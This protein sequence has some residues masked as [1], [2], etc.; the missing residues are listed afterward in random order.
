MDVKRTRQTRRTS[1]NPE[2]DRRIANRIRNGA[3]HDECAVEFRLTKARIGQIWHAESK[4][5]E[6][7]GSGNYQLEG[8]RPTTR[9]RR[10]RAWRLVHEHGYH[11]DEVARIVG[12]SRDTVMNDL[13]EHGRA[14]G[15]PYRIARPETREARCMRYRAAGLSR[16]ECC[17]M[18]GWPDD[19]K[20]RFYVS[21]YDYRARRAAGLVKPR[22]GKP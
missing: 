15:K 4:P 17:K 12:V 7:V 16:G 8:P 9:K 10:A 22:G 20:H 2:R 1:R 13:R 14:H 11:P 5:R 19:A 3:T 21:T 6:R 18:L